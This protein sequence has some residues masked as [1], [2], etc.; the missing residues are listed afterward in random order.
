MARRRSRRPR[1]GCLGRWRRLCIR[2][3]SAGRALRL[4]LLPAQQYEY[5]FEAVQVSGGLD[6]NF[7]E[8]AAAIGLSLRHR[9]HGQVLRE[10]AVLARGEHGL[11]LVYFDVVAD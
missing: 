1:S 5:F 11:A 8:R 10:D 3:L 2:G 7:L 9:A 6:Q 4:D